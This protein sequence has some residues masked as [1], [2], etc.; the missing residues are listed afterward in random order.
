M[1]HVRRT[2][3]SLALGLALITVLGGCAS[4][5]GA[6]QSVVESAEVTMPPS[7]RFDPV[8]IRVPVGTT[9]TWRNTD[10]FTHSVSVVGAGF[11]ELSLAPGQSGTITFDQPGEYPYICT[12]HAQ[13]MKGTVSVVE[14]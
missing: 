7:Y 6:A 5:A 12:Y 1:K 14:R 3:L 11:P 8:A 9:V 2:G 13:D 4:A 10:N